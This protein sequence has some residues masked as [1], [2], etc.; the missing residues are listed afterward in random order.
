MS[1]T[2]LEQSICRTLAYFD[3]ADYPL[4]KEELYAYLW[5]PPAIGYLDF[6]T[7]LSS[8]SEEIIQSK[9]GYYFLPGRG[10]LAEVRRRRLI[11]SEENLKIARKAAKKIRSVPFVRAVFVCNKVASE[12]ATTDSDVDFLIITEKNRI[13]L[14]RFFVT[15]V[16]ALF[17]LRRTD[18][19]IQD[20][21]C[22]SFYLAADNLNLA[23][24]R[25]AEDDIHFAYWLNQM[26]PVYDPENYYSRFLEANA[27][28]GKYLPNIDRRYRT[29][30]SNQVKN[31]RA[32]SLWKKA[33]EKMWQ[34]AYGKVMD[35]QARQMQLAKM[36]MSGK[37]VERKGDKG[38][39]I[40]DNILKFHEKDTRE[41]YRNKWLQKV[42]MLGI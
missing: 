42:L 32:G 41:E 20:K 37:D 1:K 4:T 10:E 28:T 18:S 29:A 12:Q 19:R 3:L 34:G 15:L 7:Y 31:T 33:W 16:L 22:L 38:V 5:Q 27:W 35:N 6:L 36:K 24:W 23:P 39:V 9:Y 21:I 8:V 25:V 13:W 26:Y 2:P 11:F 30:F 40:A 17:R 14:A